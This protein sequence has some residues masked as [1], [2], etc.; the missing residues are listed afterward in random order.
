M[1][2][3]PLPLQALAQAQADNAALREQLADAKRRLAEQTTDIREVEKIL[4]YA[5]APHG[6]LVERVRF[7][8]SLL[9]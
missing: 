5:G 3:I 1:T 4:Y 2:A 9:E 8:A 7:L 6:T